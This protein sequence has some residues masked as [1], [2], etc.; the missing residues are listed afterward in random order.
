M[1]VRVRLLVSYRGGEFHGWQ[2]Q[3]DVVT[4]EGA[5]TDAVEQMTGERRKIWGASRTDAGVHAEG[6]VAAF[7]YE[8]RLDEERFYHG[9]NHLTPDGLSVRAVEF[10]DDG[11]HPR[12][13]SRG[14]IYRYFIEEGAHRS[15]FHAPF[16]CH[17]KRELD[18]EAMCDAGTHLLGLHDFSSFRAAGCE[19][20][21]TERVMYE[22]YTERMPN[23]LVR[24]QV[25]GS[26]FLKYM[27]RNMVGTL[28]QV[29]RGRRDPDWMGE[30]LEARDRS[31]AGPTAPPNGL[32]LHRVFHPSHPWLSFA[33]SIV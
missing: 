12:H 22:V 2:I 15:P 4:A 10:V 11:F 24:V 1:P 18:V 26:A 5:L 6:Q 8:G 31:A 32:F 29:G 3:D 21:S 17:E 28:I 7:D 33:G 20:Q 9:L 13:S 27:V 30:V 23:G 16:S 19:A 14:K 25:V